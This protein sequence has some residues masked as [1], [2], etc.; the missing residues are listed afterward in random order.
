GHPATR[1][2]EEESVRNSRGEQRKTNSEHRSAAERALCSPFVLRLS[3]SASLERLLPQPL[4]H[5]P[6]HRLLTLEAGLAVEDLAVL[7]DDVDRGDPA[8][9]VLARDIVALEEQVVRVLLVL[10]VFLGV[11]ALP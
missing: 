2:W 11:A 9:A 1:Q 3:L 10:H 5:G 6:L 8:D 4:L 7:A